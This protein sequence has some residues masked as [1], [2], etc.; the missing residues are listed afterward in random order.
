VGA[1]SGA[2]VGERQSQ[3]ARKTSLEPASQSTGV[4]WPVSTMTSPFALNWPRS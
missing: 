1:T 3:E 4:N 2:S